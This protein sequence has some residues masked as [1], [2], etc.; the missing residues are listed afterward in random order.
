LRN[1]PLKEEGYDEKE[2]GIVWTESSE[3]SD[4]SDKPSICEEELIRKI[5]TYSRVK[6]PT[7]PDDINEL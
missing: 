6:T 7:M 1:Q 4:V 5:P 2:Y 3:D